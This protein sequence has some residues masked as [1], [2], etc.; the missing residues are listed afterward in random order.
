MIEKSRSDLSALAKSLS[1]A[2]RWCCPKKASR[3]LGRI[4]SARGGKVLGFSLLLKRFMVLKLTL[5]MEKGNGFHEFNEFLSSMRFW[6][7]RY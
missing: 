4:R 5:N 2:T 7:F 3:V 1:P 6:G